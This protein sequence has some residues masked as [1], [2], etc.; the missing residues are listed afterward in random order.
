MGRLG[1]RTEI[2]QVGARTTAVVPRRRD[3]GMTEA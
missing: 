2:D 3:G 1:R